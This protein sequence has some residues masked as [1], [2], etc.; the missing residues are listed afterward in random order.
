MTLFVS[1]LFFLCDPSLSVNANLETAELSIVAQY[2]L[3]KSNCALGLVAYASDQPL[4][5]LSLN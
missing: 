5:I 4:N 2:I 1:V 3:A